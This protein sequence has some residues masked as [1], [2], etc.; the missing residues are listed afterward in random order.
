MVELPGPIREFIDGLT[1]D[2]L[3]PAYL[4]VTEAGRLS[5]WGGALE[6]YGISGLEK[7]MQVGDHLP[8]LVG[9][10]PL[11]AAGV[12]LPNVQTNPRV[13]ADVYLFR[14]DQGTWILLLD[15]T[16]DV[17]KRQA[18]QQRTY[19]IS[20][21]AAQLEQEGK[22][23]YDA[24][25]VLQQ[26]VREQTKELS[27]TVRRLQQE[28]ADSRRTEQALSDSESRFRSLYNCNVIGIVFW[29]GSGNITEANDAFLDLLGYSQD[30]LRQGLVTWDGITATDTVANDE[31]ALSDTQDPACLRQREFLRKDGSRTPL[32]YGA[33]LQPGS[34]EKRVAFVVSVSQHKT[35]QAGS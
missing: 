19:D 17:R 29:D 2:L 5:D 34:F 24:N 4:L 7:N 32:L 6:S 20:L 3:A 18:L 10:L 22:S 21:Q 15:A 12:F 11:G 30:D 31:A 14:R 13:F 25:S 16:E 9:L 23:L 1:D 26:R 33:A 27:E 8:F 35:T 28:L